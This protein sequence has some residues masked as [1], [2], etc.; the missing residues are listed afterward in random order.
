LGKFKQPSKLP[1]F[2]IIG[3]AKCGTT[4]LAA[5]LDAHPKVFMARPKELNFFSSHWD[6]GLQW[7]EHKFFDAPHGVAIGEASPQYTQDPFFTPVAERI[8]SVLPDTRLIY[9]VRDPIAQMRSFH[10]HLVHKGKEPQASFKKAVRGQR[11]YLTTAAFGTQLA[12]YRRYFE[13]DKILVLTAEQLLN[14]RHA[15]FR[16]VLE[17]IDVDPSIPSPAIDEIR[18]T[19]DDKLA[20]PP[21]MAAP[22]AVWRYSSG[23]TGKLPREWRHAIR[24]RLSRPLSAEASELDAKTYTWIQTQLA[25]DLALLDEL[26]DGTLAN[27]SS[28]WSAR[29]HT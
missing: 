1:T 27:W 9:M 5:Y 10:R 25:P 13:A 2:L 23:V 16:R 4:S 20:L 14:D 6:R 19:G 24:N 12:V 26:T 15:A 11:L 21:I 22:R 3:A 17:H 8:A 29:R 28:A 7:Y 18:N